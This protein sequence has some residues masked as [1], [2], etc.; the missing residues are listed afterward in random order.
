M[1]LGSQ[2]LPAEPLETQWLSIFFEQ[3]ENLKTFTSYF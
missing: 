2:L 1:L 3:A